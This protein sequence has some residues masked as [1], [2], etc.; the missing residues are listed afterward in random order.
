[1]NLS[2]HFTLSELLESGTASR[3][4]Y[5]E[6]FN[7]ESGIINNLTALC[8]NVLEPLR[9]SLGTPI[10]ITS[11]YRCPRLNSKIGGKDTSQHRLG[12]AADIHAIGVSNQEI[13]ER[14]IALKL[15]FDQLIREYPDHRGEPRWIHVSHGPRNRRQTLTIN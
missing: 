5:T 8:V 12:Q 9:V 14:I 10:V 1:M 13:Y 15:P 3:M 2:T 4:G 7:P 11:G 6:Q